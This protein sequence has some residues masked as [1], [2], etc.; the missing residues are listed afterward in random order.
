MTAM[1]CM[2]AAGTWEHED[3]AEYA[4]HSLTN[5]DVPDEVVSAARQEET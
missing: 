3:W 4:D 2:S 1:E 5:D